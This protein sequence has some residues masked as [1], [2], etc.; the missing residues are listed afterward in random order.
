MPRTGGFAASQISGG[1]GSWVT[2][3]M[4]TLGLLIALYCLAQVFFLEKR[5][6]K[7]DLI[8]LYSS[9]RGGCDVVGV[10]LCSQVTVIG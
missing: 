1:F 7:G 8:A 10:G 4:L 2:A 5:G 3:A 6:L 9:L